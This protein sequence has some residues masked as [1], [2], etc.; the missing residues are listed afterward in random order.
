MGHFY[1]CLGYAHLWFATQGF[2]ILRHF[3]FVARSVQPLVIW[4][5]SGWSRLGG[6]G[7]VRSKDVQG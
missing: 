7:S 2:E 3:M 1:G 6:P 4:A 5:L